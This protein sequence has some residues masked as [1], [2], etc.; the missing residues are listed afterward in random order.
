M[1][2]ANVELVRRLLTLAMRP[3][4]PELAALE[5]LYHPDHELTTDW[6]VEVARYRGESGFLEARAVLDGALEGWTQVLDDVIDVGPDA[7]LVLGRVTGEGRESG[8]PVEGE[9]TA[10]V[11]VRGGRVAS[12]RFFTNRGEA[13]AAAGIEEGRR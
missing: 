11:A 5:G 13:F 1:T 7:V 9:W 6:G 12:T 2:D 4:E 8:V 10:L 3:G